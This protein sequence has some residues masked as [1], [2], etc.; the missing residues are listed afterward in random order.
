M[1]EVA[2]LTALAAQELAAMQALENAMTALDQ[3]GLDQGGNSNEN[4]RNAK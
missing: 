4:G 3:G 1:A 2:L